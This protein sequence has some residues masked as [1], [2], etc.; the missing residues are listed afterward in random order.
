MALEELERTA[1]QQRHGEHCRHQQSRPICTERPHGRSGRIGTWL[2]LVLVLLPVL[3]AVV[4]M[5]SDGWR[6]V[7]TSDNR[8]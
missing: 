1:E 4:M 5:M 6:S 8:H 3:A 7:W 2:V